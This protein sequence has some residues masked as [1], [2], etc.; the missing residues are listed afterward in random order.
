MTL[1]LAGL[2]FVATW[3]VHSLDHAR[4][5]ID[6]TSDAVVWAGTLVALMAAVALTLVIVGHETAP[7]IAAAVFPAI[8]FGVTASHFLPQWSV[9]SDP[10]L[11]DSTS[12]GWSILAAGSEVMAAVVIGVVALR[13]L[14]EHKMAWRIDAAHWT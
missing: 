3:I 8:A 6:A 9:L 1:K 12:D 11:V 13:I 4:R 5:S 2:L 14:I 10:L 7:A